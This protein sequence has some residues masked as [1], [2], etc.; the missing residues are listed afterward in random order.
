MLFRGRDYKAQQRRISDNNRRI[1]Q[2]ARLQIIKDE[3]GAK[4]RRERRQ[5]KEAKN[6]SSSD[7]DSDKD[8][9][10]EEDEY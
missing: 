4:E 5:K 8:C 3:L 6:S 10:T 7:S 9:T 1:F 2:K